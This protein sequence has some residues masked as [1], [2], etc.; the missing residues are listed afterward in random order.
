MFSKEYFT[1]NE[2]AKLFMVSPVTVRQWAQKGILNASLTAGGHRRFLRQ[3]LMRFA[4]DRG[5]TVH[6]PDSGGIKVLVVDDDDDYA[7]FLK[8]FLEK[9]NP[10]DKVEVASS[11]FD[12]GRKIQNFQP[13]IVL[14]DLMMPGLD[15]FE[16]CRSVKTDP[17][18]RAIRILAISGYAT[19]ENVRRI[20]DAGAEACF[21]KTVDR[22][23]LLSMF[24]LDEHTQAGV[25]G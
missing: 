12:A 13:D 11:G 16:V 7:A 23:R 24:N 1:P 25:E 3:E 18:T 15:G 14:L 22:D 20:L 5:L 8:Q 4:R 10:V 17:S 19:P 9:L 21:E 2:V 6:W